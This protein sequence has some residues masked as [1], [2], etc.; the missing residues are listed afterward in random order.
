MNAVVQFQA[1]RLPFHE[2][3]EERFE[4]DRAD[5]KVLVEAVFPSAKTPDSIV[6]A[7]AYCKRRNLD[8]FKR[9]VHIVPMWDK[10]R[11]D[12]VETVW[13]GISELRTTA[14]RTGQY[15]GCD[16]TE[17]GPDAKQTFK[18]TTGKGQYEQT[19]EVEVTFPEWGRMTVWRMV[20]SVRVPFV[21]PKVYWLESYGKIGRTQLPNDM[22]EKRPR[23]Q[24]E[25]CLEAAALRKAFPEEIGNELTAEEMAGQVILDGDA[26]AA[27]PT[28]LI[29]PSPPK[30]PSAPA[31]PIK[32]AE[33]YQGRQPPPKTVEH[34]AD[35]VILEGEE[36]LPEHMRSQ[37]DMEASQEHE[38]GDPADTA[39]EPDERAGDAPVAEESDIDASKAWRDDAVAFF[40]GA[41]TAKAVDVYEEHNVAPVR[42]KHF[43]GDVGD[44]DR[45]II[46]ARKRLLKKDG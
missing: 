43:P 18:G 26:A 20:N 31:A 7:L 37:H 40:D 9:P 2:L 5:W 38:T 28:K 25:K 10:K 39:P 32:V 30:A 17:F 46:R 35:G 23:G 8:I 6:M 11:N 22:W 14:F 36:N 15:A 1:P 24:L 21:G 42:D 4:V 45:A 41:K 33:S 19:R 16:E 34:D 13:P 44:V 29:A 27:E 12:Y 3:I